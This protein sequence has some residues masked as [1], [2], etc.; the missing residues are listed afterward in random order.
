MAVQD[1][2]KEHAVL[3]TIGFSG[4]R[5]FGLVLTE[6]ALLSTAGGAVG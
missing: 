2:I 3:Q 1:R 4:A 5:V 6:S